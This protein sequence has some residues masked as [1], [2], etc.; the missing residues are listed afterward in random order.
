[1][2][3]TSQRQSSS[4][5]WAADAAYHSSLG[6]SH[7]LPTIT[8]A[9]Q[10]TATFEEFWA[11]KR[12]AAFQAIYIEE[13]LDREGFAGLL[14]AYQFSSKR[15]LTDEVIAIMAE[16]PG[17]LPREPSVERVAKRMVDFIESFEEGMGDIEGV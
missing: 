9:H 11:E 5:T 6:A 10:T 15:P 13:R 14:E 12:E 17:I 1:M 8:S 7:D 16:V 4:T 3:I 2:G